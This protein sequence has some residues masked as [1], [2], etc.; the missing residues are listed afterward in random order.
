MRWFAL[1]PNKG[2]LMATR[3]I[4]LVRHGQYHHATDK[5][6]ER[7]TTLGRKQAKLVGKRLKENKIDR[8][9]VST[10]PRAQETAQIIRSEIGYRK[11]FESCDTLREC[12]PGFPKHLRKKAGY[13]DTKKLAKAQAQLNKAF[14]KYFKAPRK[15]TL[16]VI[17]CHGNVIRYLVCKV[18]GIDPL[19][20]RQMDIKQ[21]A[22]SVVEV[23]SKGTNRKLLVSHN[24]M[25]HIPK[26]QRT[27]L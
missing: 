4:I 3:T 7:L 15:D 16:E 25:G 1:S 17:V 20:W 9:V 23:R 26:H 12:T 14:A 24:D 27:F 10:M 6:L 18:L 8:M 21:C 19:V 11:A 22:I 2:V 5:E 13:T